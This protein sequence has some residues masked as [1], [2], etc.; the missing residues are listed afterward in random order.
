MEIAQRTESRSPRIG[1][2]APD[3]RAR[4]TGGE[5][6]LSK[7]RGRWVLFFSHPADFTPVCSTEFAEL[8]RRQ[9]EFEALETS[10]LG[11]SV[12]SLYS[13]LAWVR[14]IRVTLDA[15]V[16][17]PI[18]EDPSMAIGRAYGMIDEQSADSMAMRSTFFI[19]PEGVIRA[20]TCYPHN[21]GRSVDEMLRMLKALKAVS[22]AQT[23]APEGWREG[24]PL[25]SPPSDIDEDREDWFC[26]FVDA[27]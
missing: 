8:A 5:I 3:F 11:L 23:L 21:V 26:R 25:L 7:L 24:K 14:A 27:P 15:D 12:D 20:I 1:E 4:S 9:S 10:L 17:F 2:I 6:Q 16:R 18:I 22:N 13:H 19:D